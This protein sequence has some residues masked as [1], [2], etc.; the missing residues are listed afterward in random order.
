MDREWQ[1]RHDQFHTIGY[2]DGL[3]VGKEAFAQEGFNIGFKDSVSIGYNW[4]CARGITSVMAFLPHGLKEKMVETEETRNKFQRLHE[5][6]HSLSTTDALKLFNEYQ[7]R[8]AGNQDEDATCRATDANLNNQIRD[9]DVLQNY[10]RELR[11]LV[12]E[13]PLMDVRIQNESNET[14]LFTP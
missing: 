10:Y 4:A 9:I 11:S 13:F 12:D 8:K 7:K 1:R 14:S 6:I 2:R 3:I 5:S